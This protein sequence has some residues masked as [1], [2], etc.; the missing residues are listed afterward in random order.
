[1]GRDLQKP[2]KGFKLGLD[3]S[4]DTA[5]CDT[6][7]HD[8]TQCNA[9]QPSMGTRSEEVGS[10]AFPLRLHPHKVVTRH[11]ALPRTTSNVIASRAL[12]HCIP[13]TQSSIQT[14]STRLRH[15]GELHVMDDPR[16]GLEPLTGYLNS[17]HE[18]AVWC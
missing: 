8:T 10:W 12:T 11:F 17:L 7:R 9:Y 1:M 6:T 4:Y 5:T 13:P 15:V 16:V 2:R 3:T 14:S 18:A